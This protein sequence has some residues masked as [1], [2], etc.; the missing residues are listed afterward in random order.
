VWDKVAEEIDELRATDHGTPEAEDEL[1]DLLFT[2]VNV[3]RKMGLDPEQAL[4]M[5]CAKFV[6][7][8]SEMERAAA[9]EGRDLADM[10][11]EE[12]EALWRRAKEGERP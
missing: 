8:F 4:R 9:R 11:I 1:G 7:R 10:G 12:Q 5:T 6:R 3:G 2:I